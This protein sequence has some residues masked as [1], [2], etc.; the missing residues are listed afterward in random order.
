MQRHREIG[1]GECM[2]DLA[3]VNARWL[4]MDT[5]AANVPDT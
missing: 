5:L 3:G 4:K 2:V 1:G